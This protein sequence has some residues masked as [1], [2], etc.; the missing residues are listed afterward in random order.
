MS[1]TCQDV[2][3]EHKGIGPEL[4]SPILLSKDGC[5]ADVMFGHCIYLQVANVELPGK[6]LS[7][8]WA[9]ADVGEAVV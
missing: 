7:K 6:S 3:M 4:A 1:G 2:D 9:G 5:L 8:I